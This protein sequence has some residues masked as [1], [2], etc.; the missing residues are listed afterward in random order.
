ML[1]RLLAD[2]LFV[3]GTDHLQA[4]RAGRALPRLALAARLASSNA[5]YYG[6]AALAAHRAG[7]VDAAV[8][9]CERALELDPELKA[10][11]DLMSGMFLHGEHYLRVLER[12]H[13]HLKPRTYV[14]IG[15]EHGH[16]LR[17]VSRATLALGIDP[18][19]LVA[20]RLPPNVRLFTETSDEFFARHD[21]RAELGG[22]PVDLAFIDGMHHFE[23]A[24]RDF[25]NLERW[26]TPQSTI[27][28]DDCFPHD[29]RTATAMGWLGST[30]AP[31]SSLKTSR[32]HRWLS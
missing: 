21:V 26:C 5:S 4:G 29:R 31:W 3:R 11:H 12:L 13:A 24:L 25:M 16:S 20:R 28:L 19:P 18:K 10:A 23:Y 22:L 6:A 8:R 7:D 32:R 2:V 9:Y 30:S 14:E 1:A 27:V 17:L 15:V